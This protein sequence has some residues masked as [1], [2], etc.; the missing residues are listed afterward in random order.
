MYKF[1]TW[2]HANQIGSMVK[3]WCWNQKDEHVASLNTIEGRKKFEYCYKVECKISIEMMN[4]RSLIQVH[5]GTTYK[6]K[7]ATLARDFKKIYDYK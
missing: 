2:K 5:D 6:D 4:V 7:W 3:F 1:K